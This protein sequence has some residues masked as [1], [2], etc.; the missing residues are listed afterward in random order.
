[1]SPDG[2]PLLSVEAAQA[3]AV[4]PVRSTGVERVGVGEALGRVLGEEVRAPADVPPHD[5][6]AMDGYAVRAADLAAGRLELT[7]IGE[8]AAGYVALRA[9]GAGEAYQIMTGAP[10]PPGAD[11]VVMVESTERTGDRVRIGKPAQAGEHIRGR[12]EDIRAGAVVLGRGVTLGPAELGVLA[13]VRRARVL[14]ARRPMVAVLAT[15]DELRDVDEPLDPGA[16]PD[17]NSYAL[18]ALVRAAGGVPCVAP[19][20]RDD[21]ARI[22]AAIEAAR[23]ADLIV[24][25]GG[26]SVGEH[27]HVKAVLAELGAELSLWR[28]NMKP[29][30]P[31]AI[32]R[33][34][35]VPY[36]GLPGNPVSSMVSFLLFVRPA[37]RTA[38]GCAQPFDLPRVQVVLD[39]PVRARGER[40]SYLR[41]RV[42]AGADGHLH[43]TVMPHQGSHVLTSMVG[44]NGLVILEPGTHDLAAGAAATALL[45]GSV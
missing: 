7:V 45:I 14:V 41:A 37:I 30:K 17:T 26:V 35:D 2:D 13:S 40:R 34:G 31:V 22:R 24:S 15:G 32:A 21:P 11:A 42:Q 36:F 5:N 10:I 1:M 16:I 28:V 44:A 6:S 12:G 25:S 33:L 20:V 9:L 39:G 27:D 4:A 38:L 23:S 3:H 29:G 43:A 19:I 18:A 8:V